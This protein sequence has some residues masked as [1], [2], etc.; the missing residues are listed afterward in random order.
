MARL[1][2]LTQKEPKEITV[3]DKTF[4]ICRCGL[5]KNVDGL[6]DQTHL[7]TK[8]EEEGSTYFY[9]KDL[10]R[11]LVDMI[12][13]DED[14]DECCGGSGCCSGSKDACGCGHDHHQH[15]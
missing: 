8:D 6:C 1:V 5:T 13:D 7:I 10:N 2:A 14:M 15:N 4:K 3:G 11:E 9:D 12:S